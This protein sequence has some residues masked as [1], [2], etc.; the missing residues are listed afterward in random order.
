[1]IDQKDFRVPKR[2]NII[3]PYARSILPVLPKLKYLGTLAIFVV[4]GIITI[5]LIPT[6]QS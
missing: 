4:D 6:L 5:H 1:M 3:N 2:F